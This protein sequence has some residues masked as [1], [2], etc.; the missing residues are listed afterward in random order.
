MSIKAHIPNTITLCNLLCGCMAII[1]TFQ[2]NDPSAALPGYFL[3]MIFIGL[4]ALFDFCDGFAAR[5]LHAY[6][7][8]GKELDSL[9]DL[10]SFGVAPALMLFSFI[11]SST[12]GSPVAWLALFIAAMGALRL[13]RF[14]VDD[15]QTTSF[16]G[17][18]IPASA[19]FWIGAIGWMQVHGCPSGGVMVTL[20]II[21]SLLMVSPLP[22]FSLKFKSWGWRDNLRRYLIIAA[23]VLFV[24]TDG[25]AGLAWTVLLYILISMFGRRIDA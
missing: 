5:L 13:A 18:P 22:M 19:L 6:S 3:P 17:L 16:I 12:G 9:S 23:A 20:I 7:A 21:M 25:V 2:G 10:V 11:S 4:A 15:R 14:N 1:F 24:I 8:V